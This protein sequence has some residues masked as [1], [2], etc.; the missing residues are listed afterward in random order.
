MTIESP[1]YINQLFFTK[2][3]SQKM[4]VSNNSEDQYPQLQKRHPQP[5]CI[6]K[7]YFLQSL[8]TQTHSAFLHI[9][10]QCLW[11][12][13]SVKHYLS[14]ERELSCSWSISALTLS[15]M[16]TGTNTPVMWDSSSSFVGLNGSI[17][18]TNWNV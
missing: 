17:T 10:H 6:I 16:I 3:T 1:Y 2:I 15:Q 18:A 12:S 11:E 4:L 8:S 9:S 7:I 13:A 14:E 5:N